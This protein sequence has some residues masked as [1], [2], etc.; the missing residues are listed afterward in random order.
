MI[1]HVE[2]ISRTGYYLDNYEKNALKITI[3]ILNSLYRNEIFIE[4]ESRPFVPEDF[5]NI[6]EQLNEILCYQGTKSQSEINNEFRCPTYETRPNVRISFDEYEEEEEEE[7]YDE[8]WND[9]KMGMQASNG[10]RY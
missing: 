2:S 1:L 5:K 7:D 4:A 10:K 3:N 8:D 6:A 9:S